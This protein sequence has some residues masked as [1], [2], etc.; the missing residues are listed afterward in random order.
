VSVALLC[1]ILAAVAC[2]LPGVFLLLRGMSLLGDAI[3]H[4]VLPG[5]V[6]AFLWTGSVG[7]LPVY[8]GAAAVGLFTVF[9]IET[10]NR[11]RRMKEDASI[12]VV[13]PALFAF[14]V[15]LVARY[16]GQKD[17]DQDC[18]LY[19]DITFAG[20]R[21]VEFLGSY[22]SRPALVLSIAALF[23]ILFVALFYKELKL[24]TFDPALAASLGISPVAVHY[25]LMGVV[26]L[27]TVASF[28]SVGAIL[29][30]AFLVVPAAA[31]RLW[32]DRLPVT[33]ALACGIG[34]GAAALGYGAARALDGSIAGWMASM[35]GAAFGASWMLSP[36]EG[37]LGRF[38]A[39]LRARRRLEMG[40]LIE[41]L[42]RAPADAEDLARSLGWPRPRVDRVVR[43]LVRAGC[44]EVAAAGALRPLP[45]GNNLLE[46]LLG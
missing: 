26:S 8:V 10:V 45:A 30:V 43:E 21:V 46:D 40:L 38:V 34:A 12:A 6:I 33:L 18:V 13:F 28:E 44:A 4:A 27:T 9:L 1:G 16:A 22:V 23:N 39:R 41:R 36:R 14:G 11:T 42:A 3:S 25:L 2:A 24:A 17:L 35:M 5:I 37:L 29:V 32:T 15:L 20:E 31:A 19:G 7:A